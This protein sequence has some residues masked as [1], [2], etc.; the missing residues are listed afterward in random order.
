MAASYLNESVAFVLRIER[1]LYF[2]CQCVE[3]PVRS[4]FRRG[5]MKLIGACCCALVICSTA[6]SRAFSLH[7]SL[8]FSAAA[9]HTDGLHSRLDNCMRSERMHKL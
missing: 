8:K 2:L 3:L 5:R 1:V 4:N 6:R 9:E 7:I